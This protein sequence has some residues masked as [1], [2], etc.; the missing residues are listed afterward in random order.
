TEGAPNHIEVLAKLYGDFE[1]DVRRTIG[2]IRTNVDPDRDQTKSLSVS[3][4]F[5][6]QDF[7]YLKITVE[8][9]L[10]LNV[11]VTDERS[12]LLQKTTAFLELAISRKRKDKKKIIEEELTGKAAQAAILGVL[13]GMTPTFS[14]GQLVKDRAVFDEQLADAFN[15][16][17]ITLDGA[18]RSA[19]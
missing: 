17:Y 10:R 14:A 16:A 4:I 1:H 18:L 3:R 9:P 19:L 13:E 12:T 6:N 8:R 15:A 7:G 11:A 2:Q 5:D